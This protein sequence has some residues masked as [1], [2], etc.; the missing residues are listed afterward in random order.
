MSRGDINLDDLGEISNCSD[1]LW[2]VWGIFKIWELDY[3]I[4][5]VEEMSKFFVDGNI[6]DEEEDSNN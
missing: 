5:I 4:I 3:F 1:I 2:I 6:S